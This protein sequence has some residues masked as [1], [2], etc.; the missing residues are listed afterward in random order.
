MKKSSFYIFLQCNGKKEQIQS[1][2]LKE[3]QHRLT[4]LTGNSVCKSITE[5]M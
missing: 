5:I 1:P 2:V 4:N 3:I